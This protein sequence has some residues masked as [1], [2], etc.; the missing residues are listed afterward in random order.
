MSFATR[1]DFDR[2]ELSRL[3]SD[4]SEQLQAVVTAALSPELREERHVSE[5]TLDAIANRYLTSVFVD[6]SERTR[7]EFAQYCAEHDIRTEMLAELLVELQT[8]LLERAEPLSSVDSEELRRL[9]SHDIATISAACSEAFD[10]SSDTSG[11]AV[12]DEIHSQAADVTE[13]SAEITALTE[14]QA[15]NMDDLSQEVGDISAAVEEIAASADEINTQSDEAADLAE[16]GCTRASELNQR[17]EDIHT[18]ATG[19][20][21]AVEAL[22]DHTEDIGEF[23]DTIDDIADQT[24]LLALNAS[25]EAARVDEGEGF[26]VVA[27]EVKSLAEESQEE[28]ARIRSLVETIDG[29]VDRVVDDIESVHEQTDAGRTEAARAVETFEAIDE[30]NG[31]L[32]DSMADVATATDQQARSTEELAMMADEANRKTEMILDE[33]EGID[34]SNREL[35][36]MLDSSA[37]ES[38]DE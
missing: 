23:V 35:L 14:Q 15:G 29:A 22:A 38:L 10:A 19:V 6:G 32:S 12:I 33:A 20:H 16:E 9:T 2:S 28:A 17:I 31:R 11:S 24:N 7:R 34:Q 26:A 5:A 36:E 1:S 25:I 18:R 3:V 37:G 30:I 27:N 13:R 21:E 4:D 8:Q